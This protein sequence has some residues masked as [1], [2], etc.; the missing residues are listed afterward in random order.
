[1]EADSLTT[2]WEVAEE[3]NVDL[4]AVIQHLK[5]TGKVKKLD[6]QVPHELTES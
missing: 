2:P 5:E 4:F 6:K 3:L 1:M